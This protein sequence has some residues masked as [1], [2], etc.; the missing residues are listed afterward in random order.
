MPDF[1]PA[2]E[3]QL[4]CRTLLFTL[5]IVVHAL[6]FDLLITA[7]YQFLIVYVLSA[8]DALPMLSHIAVLHLV[9]V[10]VCSLDLLE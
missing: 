6:L 9:K 3:S 4:F 10:L 2:Q 8:I 5:I 1:L 7:S